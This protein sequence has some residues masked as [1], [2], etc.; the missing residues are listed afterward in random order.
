MEFET[1]RPS[2]NWL[3][4]ALDHKIP[5]SDEKG[6]MQREYGRLNVDGTILSKRRI[7]IL[8]EG[9]TIGDNS[10]PDPVDEA[11]D[12]VETIKLEEEGDEE[13]ERS[14]EATSVAVNGAGRKDPPVVRDWNDPRL[15]TL[16]A[17]RRRGIPP[18]ALKKFVLD[19]G[20]TKAN[21]NTMTH[22]LDSTIR[23]Y[24]ERT[25]PRLMLVLDPIK[26]VLD[27]F[28]TT[29]SKHGMCLLIRKTR[30]KAHT[31][32]RSV[33]LSTLTGTISER[34]MTPIFSV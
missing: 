15:F 3:L 26:V 17:L 21:A 23:T 30:P 11:A 2:Y 1:L 29:T 34:K 33:G 16:V 24:L 25:V 32:F 12:G 9:T 5:G 20:V 8:V 27:T 28:R 14:V 22:A 4:E 7:R 13:A 19:L 6:P 10:G 18:G 31:R